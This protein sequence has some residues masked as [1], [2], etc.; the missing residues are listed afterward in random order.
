MDS[1]MDGVAMFGI[2]LGM[3]PVL[4]LLAHMLRFL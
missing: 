3:M 2:V 1:F 4:L